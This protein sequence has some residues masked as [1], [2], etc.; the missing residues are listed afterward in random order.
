[1]RL[2]FQ[3]RSALKFVSRII[4][5]AKLR[6]TNLLD[7][8]YQAHRAVVKQEKRSSKRKWNYPRSAA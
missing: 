6:G 8:L 4:P 5:L 3:K 2:K 7:E 1:M